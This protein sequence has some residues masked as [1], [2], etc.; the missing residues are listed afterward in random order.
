MKVLDRDYIRLRCQL[1]MM[2]A[3]LCPYVGTTVG[4]QPDRRKQLTTDQK[5]RTVY[6]LF[7]K[8]IE[9]DHFMNEWVVR[10]DPPYCHVELAFEDNMCSSIH[11]RG[12][13]FFSKRS[14]LADRYDIV[15]LSVSSEQYTRMVEVCA[16]RAALGIPFSL[17]RMLRCSANARSV[18][19]LPAF[20]MLRCILPAFVSARGNPSPRDGTFCSEHVTEVLQFGGVLAFDID[21]ATITPSMLSRILARHGCAIVG[22]PYSR[23]AQL[24]NHPNVVI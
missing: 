6:V 23:Q 18:N 19:C 10:Y 21:A 15:T 3:F 5:F 22:T 9:R 24:R 20:F 4:L 12:T 11:F 17:V 16:E 2:S 14:L 1:G 8:L 7:Y 13:V